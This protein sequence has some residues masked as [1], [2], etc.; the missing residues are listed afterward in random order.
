MPTML[1]LFAGAFAVSNLATICH[2]PSL[3]GLSHRSVNSH[4]RIE[5]PPKGSESKSTRS[6]P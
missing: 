6:S 2:G 1:M 5:S 3:Q 4:S